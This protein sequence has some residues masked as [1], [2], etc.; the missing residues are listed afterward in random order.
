MSIKAPFA[1]FLM[2]N[3]VKPYTATAAATAVAQKL[4]GRG[5]LTRAEAALTNAFLRRP[6]ANKTREQGIAARVSQTLAFGSHLAPGTRPVSRATPKLMESLSKGEVIT[7]AQTLVAVRGLA[8]F[9]ADG[10]R[11]AQGAEDKHKAWIPILSMG[12]NI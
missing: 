2:R 7:K 3:G 8:A 10:G 5:A 12:P 11:A 1:Q 6:D 9:I 4:D